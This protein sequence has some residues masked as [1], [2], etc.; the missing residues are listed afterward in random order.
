MKVLVLSPSNEGTIAKCSANLYKALASTG[1][2]VTCCYL[3]RYNNGEPL[4]DNCDYLVDRTINSKNDISLLR[5]VKWL[6]GIKGKEN[7]DITISTLVVVNLLNVLAGGKD[8][9]VGIFHAPVGQSRE[10]GI[11][12]FLRIYLTYFFFF[13]FLDLL[14]C[15]SEEVKDSVKRIISI[16]SKKVKVIYNAHD[17]SVIES[18]SSAPLSES[19]ESIMNRAILYCGRIDDNKA[20][21]RAIDAFCKANLSK[22]F[23]LVIIGPDPYTKWDSIQIN[24][25]SS[26]RERIFYLGPQKNP[27]NFIKKSVALISTSYSEGLPGVVIESL[28]L[29]RPVLSTN[30]SRGVWEIFS[31]NTSYD[32]HLA[33]LFENECGVISSNLSFHNPSYYEDDI[34]NLAKGIEVIVKKRKVLNFEFKNEIEFSTISSK[35]QSVI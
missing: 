23:N 5:K 18:L 4:F 29:G 12:Y 27:Y 17:C 15:V 6:N 10:F 34:N 14:S 28:I 22:E 24:I 30:S 1:V 32:K 16:P 35:L 21:Q 7:P 2:D 26:F 20:P 11:L 25:P 8:K 31:A 33:G 9:K 13:P 19:E 3:Y